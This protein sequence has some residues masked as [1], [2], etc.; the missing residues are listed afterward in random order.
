MTFP[1]SIKGV[2]FDPSGKVVLLMNERNEW[3]L[4]G[5]RIEVGESPVNCVEREVREELLIDVKAKILLDAY[6]FEVV[7]SKHV[8]IV[9]YGCELCGPF[10]PRISAEHTHFELF[11]PELLPRN[12]PEGYRRSIATSHS[13]LTA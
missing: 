11:V 2:F 1:V 4:P 10:A 5:G 3:E 12:L 8:F 6:L 9:T 7:P 13:T